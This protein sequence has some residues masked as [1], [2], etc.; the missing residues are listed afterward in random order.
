[1]ISPA[2]TAFK[3]RRS[4]AV[5]ERRAGRSASTAPPKLGGCQWSF[6]MTNPRKLAAERSN[7]IFMT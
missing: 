1:M 2:T 7:L 3:S 6:L 4:P 5:N